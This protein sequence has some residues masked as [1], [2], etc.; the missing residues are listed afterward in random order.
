ML[1]LMLTML[2]LLGIL[3]LLALAEQIILSRKEK[4]G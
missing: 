4:R 2:G 3:A 1:D